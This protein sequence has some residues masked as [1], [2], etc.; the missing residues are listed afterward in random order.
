MVH[1][2]RS[3]SSKR[4]HRQRYTYNSML[5]PFCSYK[6]SSHPQDL[7][8]F[9]QTKAFQRL[10]L[11]IFLTPV[12][13]LSSSNFERIVKDRARSIMVLYY[14]GNCDLC[15]SLQG[16]LYNVGVTFR[17]EPKC[18]IG[19]LN[20]D[21]DPQICIEQDIP[22][23]PRFKVYSQHNK[24]G[25]VYEPGTNQESFSETNMTKFMNA[26]CGTQ[27][28]L[29]GRLNEKVSLWQ[30]GPSCWKLRLNLRNLTK[31]TST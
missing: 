5:S 26:L 15:N 16:T 29:R 2:Q 27:R 4:R 10:N 1:C 20:C 12:I 22:H 30:T 6:G 13:D 7:I 9:I 17:N 3:I 23:Y 28:I 25:V 18:L 21:A 24:D 14:N 8:R 19:R 11:G 31:G